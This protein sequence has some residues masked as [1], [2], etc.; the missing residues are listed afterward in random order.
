[1]KSF[2]KHINYE[3][4]LHNG[5]VMKYI[6]TFVETINK[7]LFQCVNSI[8]VV[9]NRN[10]NDMFSFKQKVSFAYSVD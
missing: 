9:S 8:N 6:Y 4:F 10:V 3:N 5:V 7:D 1:M 2:K